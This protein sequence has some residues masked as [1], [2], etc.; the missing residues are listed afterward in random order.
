MLAI[1]MRL[2]GVE[3]DDDGGP[4]GGGRTGCGKEPGGGVDRGGGGP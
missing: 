4:L 2:V 3:V 1:E